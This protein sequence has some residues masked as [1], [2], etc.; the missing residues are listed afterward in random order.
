MEASLKKSP[1]SISDKDIKTFLTEGEKRLARPSEIKSNLIIEKK[2]DNVEAAL[3]KKPV[4]GFKTRFAANRCLLSR[5]G[6]SLKPS[7]S[8]IQQTGSI[9]Y[10]GSGY[11][12]LLRIYHLGDLA[13]SFPF[14]THSPYLC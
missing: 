12:D 8:F 1:P 6:F 11:K 5:I 10:L 9:E 4:A 7:P 3:A 14:H 13:E 2:I